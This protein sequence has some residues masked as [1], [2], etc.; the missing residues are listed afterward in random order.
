MIEADLR[1]TVERRLPRVEHELPVRPE[2]RCALS[3]VVAF[4]L[5]SF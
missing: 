4:M 1:L 5:L 2:D 3:V